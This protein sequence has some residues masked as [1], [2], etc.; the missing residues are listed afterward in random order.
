MRCERREC[1]TE[2]DR[3][4]YGKLVSD[5][6][7]ALQLGHLAQVNQRGQIAPLFSHHEPDIGCASEQQG[8]RMCFV[9]PRQRIELRWCIPAGMERAIAIVAASEGE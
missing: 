4:A 1:I 5:V 9:V 2:R 7:D 6:N 3:G 8:L